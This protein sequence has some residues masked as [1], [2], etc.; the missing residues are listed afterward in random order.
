MHTTRAEVTVADCAKK[1]S[2][3]VWPLPWHL[4]V[5]CVLAQVGDRG[6]FVGA[7]GAD[8]S[9]DCSVRSPGADHRV[10]APRAA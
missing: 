7:G 9:R 3:F 4:L 2:I 10:M 1:A 5:G 6:S 8:L